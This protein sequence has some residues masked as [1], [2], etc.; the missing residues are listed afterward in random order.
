MGIDE[1][2]P[3]RRGA[4]GVIDV[5]KLAERIA[6]RPATN[7]GELEGAGT[8]SAEFAMQLLQFPFRAVFGDPTQGGPEGAGGQPV[9][10]RDPVRAGD[11]DRRPARLDGGHAVSPDGIDPGQIREAMFHPRWAAITRADLWPEAVGTWTPQL[12]RD[13]RLLVPADV[14]VLVVPAAGGVTAVPTKTVIPASRKGDL[15]DQ[16][17]PRPPE[18]FGAPFDREPGVHLHVAMPDGLTRGDAGAARAE[19]TPAGNPTDCPRCPTGG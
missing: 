9:E 10:L 13:T 1:T 14:Q 7:T 5:A 2:V 3:F 15:P 19:N 18:P 8:Q 17:M 16:V 6:A 12:P 4:P 11:R